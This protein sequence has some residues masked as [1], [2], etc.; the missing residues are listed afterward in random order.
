MHERKVVH[1]ATTR[2]TFEDLAHLRASA[3]DYGWLLV[4]RMSPRVI[5]HTACA[6]HQQ[7]C[8]VK[9]QTGELHLAL[10]IHAAL[11]AHYG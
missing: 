10:P 7:T 6:G 1:Y 2:S 3:D 5:P 9:G 4:T 8:G 11:K